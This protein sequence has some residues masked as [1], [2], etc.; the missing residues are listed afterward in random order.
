MEA[1]AA[2][3]RSLRPLAAFAAIA[4]AGLLAARTASLGGGSAVAG[5]VLLIGFAIGLP[6]AMLVYAFAHRRVGI[7]ALAFCVGLSVN[8]VY[9]ANAV[10]AN[11]AANNTNQFWFNNCCTQTFACPSGIWDLLQSPAGLTSNTART[12]GAGVSY[13]Y[14]SDTFSS[15]QSL[16][17]NTTTA[18]FYVTNSSSSKTCDFTGELLW[19]HA[20][21]ATT[22]SLGVSTTQ[23]LATNTPPGSQMSFNW[24]TS[25]VSSFADGDRLYFTLTFTSA[26]SNCN[27]SQLNTGINYPSNFTTA[28]IVSEV[29]VGFL[30][31]A[32]AIPLAMRWR[33]RRRP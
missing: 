12:G 8:V 23:T 15:S 7:I 16:Q 24:A 27:N 3:T 33:K 13:T 5:L 2:V 14:C 11:A 28:T 22:S 30:L 25:A 18:N 32:P 19:Y 31:V 20:A 29:V 10:P 26:G 6:V 4:A 1:E 17:A 9:L 21:S